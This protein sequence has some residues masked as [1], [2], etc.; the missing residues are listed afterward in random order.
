MAF[1]LGASGATMTPQQL[2]SLY[3]VINPAYGNALPSSA[4]ST[5]AGWQQIYT[6][7]GEGQSSKGIYW[8]DANG[9]ILDKPGGNVMN[10]RMFVNGGRDAVPYSESYGNNNLLSDF[11]KKNGL[12]PDQIN[13][14]SIPDLQN[15]ITA[16]SQDPSMQAHDGGFGGFLSNYLPGALAGAV[17]GYGGSQL[18]S[19]LGGAGSGGAGAGWTSGYDLAGG[20]SFGGVGGV[21]SGVTGGLDQIGSDWATGQATGAAGGSLPQTAGGLTAGNTAAGGLGAGVNGTTGILQKLQQLA[22]GGGSNASTASRILSG[23]GTSQ[24]L[25]SLA[26]T[27]GATALGAYS[28]DQ[29]TGSLNE[30]A[31]KYMAFGAPSRDR[32]EASYAPGFSMANEPGY[33]DALDET[34]QA[35][36]RKASTGGNVFDNPGVSQEV[37]KGVNSSFAFPALQNYRNQNASTGGYSAFNTAAPGTAA[38][39]A[40]SQGGLLS[41]LAG[42][43]SDILNPQPQPQQGFSLAD[44][45][46]QFSLNTGTSLA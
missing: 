16:F 12:N 33:K 27:L 2:Q 4:P 43:V 21:G 35:Y 46:K 45:M 1:D 42:G 40:N 14:L 9:Q 38:A 15:F 13:T 11:A 25:L 8:Q 36:L 17:L 32:Y 37:L 34:M 41:T 26:G 30:L 22:S 39:A 29:K 7:D 10:P 23:S 20:G 28:A 19:G 24:D 31:D 3:A 44:L 6:D 18:L 5:Q